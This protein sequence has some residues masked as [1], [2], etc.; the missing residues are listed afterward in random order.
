MNATNTI[1]A[2]EEAVRAALGRFHAAAKVGDAAALDAVLAT[3]LMYSHSNAKVQD[4]AE[5]IAG[6]VRS[7][8]DFQL[9][10]GWTVRVYNDGTCA[11]IHG[12][13]DAHNPGD[14]IV[15]LHFMMMWVKSGADWLLVGRHAAKLPE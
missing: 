15:P 11:M 2:S 9:R 10:E 1:A 13:V 12:M 4:K 7:N 3:D 5:C 14:K 8:I 6:L